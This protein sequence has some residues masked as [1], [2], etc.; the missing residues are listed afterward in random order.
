MNDGMPTQPRTADGR[1]L[2]SSVCI[3]IIDGA[4]MT[5][6][7]RFFLFSGNVAL[8]K[9]SRLARCVRFG[10]YVVSDESS[11]AWQLVHWYLVAMSS[12]AGPAGTASAPSP[13]N[14]GCAGP[15][16]CSLTHCS[17]SSAVF[18]I[19]RKRML[20]CDSPQYSLHCPR[21]VPGLSAL[22]VSS[23]VRPGTTSRVPESSGTQKLW[24]TLQVSASH[25]FSFR[26]TWR[27]AGIT[28]S[29][30]VTT[31]AS[32]YSNSHHHCLPTTVTSSA[33]AF[34]GA[35][36]S[37]IVLIVGTA[38]TASRSAGTMVQPISS[39]VLP[40]ICFGLSFLPAR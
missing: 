37:K 3:G 15:C 28:S 12:W 18:A 11:K 20:A 10:P 32:V 26:C 22:R 8:A 24:I 35:A 13:S 2:G 4:F 1:H 23:L 16:C 33:S 21:K 36:R 6:F 38:T 27:P 31:L 9:K 34:G 30:A 19:T 40:W 14:R 25:A 5:Q 17:K 39:R 29:S 7:T